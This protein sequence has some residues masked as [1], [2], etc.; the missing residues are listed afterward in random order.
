MWQLRREDVDKNMAAWLYED[1]DYFVHSLVI[2]NVNQACE[3]ETC[4]TQTPPDSLY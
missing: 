1:A 4:L 3:S 2:R